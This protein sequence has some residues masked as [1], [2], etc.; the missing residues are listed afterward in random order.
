MHPASSG[1]TW[2]GQG[3]CVGGLRCF[4]PLFFLPLQDCGSHAPEALGGWYPQLWSL[5][6]TTGA[7]LLGTS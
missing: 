2:N 3:G 7:F 5:R 1:P 6:G 4:Q